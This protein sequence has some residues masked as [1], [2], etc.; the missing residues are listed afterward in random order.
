MHF[1]YVV[2]PPSMAFPAPPPLP[3]AD[4]S[5]ELLRE[6]I[7]VS[8]EQLA[9]LRAAHESAN[10]NARWQAFLGRWAEEF[11][12]VG[13]FCQKSMPL[14]ERAF[15]RLLDEITRRLTD[16][17]SGGIDDEFSLSEFLDRYGMRLGQLGTL[18]NTLG[19]IADA[20]RQM[21]DGTP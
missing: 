1:Q 2:A 6:L 8:R 11:P 21:G 10:N 18:L 16:E 12:E 19:P 13:G 7:D 4:H 15:L 17:D 20:S 14:V 9:Y 5:A 3:A